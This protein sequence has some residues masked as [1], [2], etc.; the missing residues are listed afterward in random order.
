MGQPSTTTPEQV[1][2][3][4]R[5]RGR[6]WLVAGGVVLVVLATLVVVW[7]LAGGGDLQRV[8]R[9]PDATIAAGTAQV[10]VVGAVEG[11][12]IIGPFALTLAEGEVDLPGQRA[13]LRRDLA[14]ASGIPLLDRLLPGPVEVVHIGRATYLRL[15]V[16]GERAWTR[17]GD[18]EDAADQPDLTGPGL[19]NPVA[20][21]G[22]LRALD[23]VPQVVGEEA[24]RG[25]PSTRYRVRIDLD[26][27]AAALTGRAEDVAR[28]LRRLHGRTVLPLTVWLDGDDRI[29][30]LR[31]V[32]ESE[33]AGS[34]VTVTTDL[35]LFDFGATVDIRA[36]SPE[37]LVPFPAEGLR[38]LDL[39]ARLRE[40]LGR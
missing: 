18:D 7:R 2:D 11:L 38:D 26:E 32:L 39:F 14:G 28:G 40:L 22:L 13:H 24:V 23:G 36:P 29:T 27:A 33:L 19:T 34:R 1:A 8:A 3:A 31:Y 9:A 4:R 16:D 30:R 15:P 10:A 17:L 20:A 37:Q 12:P 5:A 6:R 25:Q 21:L 35:E